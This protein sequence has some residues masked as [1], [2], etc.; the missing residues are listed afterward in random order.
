[1]NEQWKKFIPGCI[2]GN[3]LELYEFIIYGYFANIIGNLFFP[4]QDKYTALMAAF[5]VF[6]T[7]SIIRPFSAVILGHL[8]DKLGRRISLI[9]SVGIMAFSTLCIGLL[10]TYS[11]IGLTAPVML[12]ICRIAQGLSMTSEEVGA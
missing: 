3:I 2:A 5:A 9:L 1:M 11:Q 12:I 7:G 10:P 6:A 4:T 8:G